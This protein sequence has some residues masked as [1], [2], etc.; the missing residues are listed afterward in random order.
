M[1]IFGGGIHKEISK[2]M[3]KTLPRKDQST[4]LQGL[5]DKGYSVPEISKATEI[6]QQSI[7]NRINAHRGR[8]S[9]LYA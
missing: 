6:S 4:V 1:S 7:Y 3:L 9:E 2:E 8:K 5:Y